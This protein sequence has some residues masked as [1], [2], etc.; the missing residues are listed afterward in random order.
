MREL[1]LGRAQQDLVGVGD[2]LPTLPGTTPVGMDDR[3][4]GGPLSQQRPLQGTGNLDFTHISPYLPAHYVL[5]ADVLK[6]TEIDPTGYDPGPV[7]QRQVREARSPTP[8]SPES[9]AAG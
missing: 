7:G 3:A 8:D 1:G 6:G 5:G 4:G 2:V 9:G